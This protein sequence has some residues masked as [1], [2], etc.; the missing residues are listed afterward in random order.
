MQVMDQI[1]GVNGMQLPWE[2][3][4]LTEINRK[5]MSLY[6]GALLQLLDRN[7]LKRPTMRAFHR[8]CQNILGDVSTSVGEGNFNE[9]NLQPGHLK[10]SLSAAPERI[11][12]SSRFMPSQKPANSAEF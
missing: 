6:K 3:E 12:N 5:K 11:P 4:N 8:T 1:E 10:A 9:T 7:P 2:G